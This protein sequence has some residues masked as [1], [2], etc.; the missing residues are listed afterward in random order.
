MA[1]KFNPFLASFDFVGPGGSFDPA[2]PGPIGGGTPDVGT[3]TRIVTGPGS[4]AVP[5]IAFTDNGDS[6]WY[7]PSIGH[8][9]YGGAS[10]GIQFGIVPNGNVMLAYGGHIKF[11][12]GAADAGAEDVGIVRISA[13]MLKVTDAS[14]GYGSLTVSAGGFTTAALQFGSVNTGFSAL[15]GMRLD[16]IVNGSQMWTTDAQGLKVYTAN[17]V[18]SSKYT[19]NPYGNTGP[20]ISSAGGALSD[21][22]IKNDAGDTIITMTS[23][24]DVIINGI[25]NNIGK[26]TSSTVGFFNANSSAQRNTS[27]GSASHATGTSGSPVYEDDLFDNYTIAQVVAALRSYGLLA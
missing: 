27:G 9:Y 26:D 11:N 14:S 24:G 15:G 23:A 2:N 21:L 25:T 17:G 16:A 1:F 22:L 8:I 19:F 20:S 18:A 12:A 7:S 4:A 5:A 13:G 10:R 3:F 6:G